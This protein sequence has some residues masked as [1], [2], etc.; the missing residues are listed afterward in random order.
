MQHGFLAAHLAKAENARACR[1]IVLTPDG[2]AQSLLVID[3]SA[4]TFPKDIQTQ[5]YVIFVRYPLSGTG[6]PECYP[7]VGCC[8]GLLWA[9]SAGPEASSY[10]L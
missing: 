4:N 6:N 8:L 10:D 3:S 9:A 2:E 1:C 7:H 5:H